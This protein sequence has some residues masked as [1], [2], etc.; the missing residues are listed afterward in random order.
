MEKTTILK[1][2]KKP[3]TVPVVGFLFCCLHALGGSVVPCVPFS[4]SP[5]SCSPPSPSGASVGVIGACGGECRSLVTTNQINFQKCKK[6]EQPSRSARAAGA[7]I[8]R[9]P[10]IAFFSRAARPCAFEG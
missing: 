4:V 1:N 5:L 9:S 8:E 10:L 3:T 7:A 6:K 2:K